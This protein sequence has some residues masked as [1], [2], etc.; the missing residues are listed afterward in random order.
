M[1]V[2]SY[3][4]W[5]VT[6][7]HHRLSDLNSRHLF[8]IVLE[9]G[10]SRIKVPAVQLLVKALFLACR[11]CLL[12]GSSH[13]GERK[14]WSKLSGV[15]SYKDTN[16]MVRVPP[17]WPHWN[18]SPKDPISKYHHTITVGIE[19]QHMNSVGWG[20]GEGPNSG[21]SNALYIKFKNLQ[22]IPYYQP[23]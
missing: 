22:K 3:S 1:W 20:W 16:P 4:A 13:D 19:L 17:S 23:W 2:L 9:D 15:S 21:Y 11:Q 18:L 10:K 14:R 8:L 7:K 6:S 5:P 12:I